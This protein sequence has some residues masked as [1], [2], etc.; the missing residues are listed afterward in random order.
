MSTDIERLLDTFDQMLRICQEALS[1]T[2]LPRQKQEARDMLRDYFSS[3]STKPKPGP[4]S[5][6]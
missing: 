5:K 1:P 2:A 3:K 6:P 4:N